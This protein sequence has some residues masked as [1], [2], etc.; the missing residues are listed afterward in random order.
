MSRGMENIVTGPGVS[1]GDPEPSS[2]FNSQTMG[3][4]KE[5]DIDMEIG[6]LLSNMSNS[7]NLKLPSIKR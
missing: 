5:I 2:A 4:I 1:F 7:S 3:K 6:G